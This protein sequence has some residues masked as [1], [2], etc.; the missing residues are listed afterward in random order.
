V[1]HIVHQFGMRP[2]QFVI[3]VDVFILTYAVLAITYHC[4]PLDSLGKKYI[5]G[6]L[7]LQGSACSYRSENYH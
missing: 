1:Q 3:A 2:Y 5:P 7:I 4:L 6:K